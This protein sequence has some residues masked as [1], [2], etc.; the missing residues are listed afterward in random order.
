MILAENHHVNSPSNMVRETVQM[1]RL[2]N[3]EAENSLH[4][5]SDQNPRQG[6]NGRCRNLGSNGTSSQPCYDEND[7]E[8]NRSGISTRDASDNLNANMQPDVIHKKARQQKEMTFQDMYN[9]QDLFDD[10]DDDSDWEPAQE[11]V[12]IKKWFC[13][14]CTMV[15]L[16]DT[17]HCDIC[18]E[19]K[20]SGIL[21]HGFFASPFSQDVG[22]AEVESEIKERHRDLGCPISTLN[23]STAVGFDERM[24]LHS[25][26]E[27]KSHPHPERPDRLRAISAS[28]ATAGIFPG[29]CYPISAR[30]ITQEELKKV[31][32]LEHIEAVELTSHLL[33]SY[34]T[35]DT[36]A[37]E[38]SA[39]AA[40]LAA[41]LCA[42]LATAIF[43]GRAKNGFALVRPPGHHAGVRQAMGF[44]LH[45]NAAV[46]ALAAQVAGAKKVL[47]VD[48]DVHHG[49]GTQEIFDQNKSV[50]YISLHRHEGGKF[51]PGTGAAHEVGTMGAEGYCVNIPWSRGGVGDNDYVFAFQHVVL[52]IASEFAPDLTIISAGFDAARGDPLGCCDVTPAGYAQMTQM[53]TALSGGKLLVILEGGYNLR[54]ISSSATAVIKVLL[55]EI[56]E[57]GLDILPSK[58]GVQTVLEVLQI[59]MNFWPTLGPRFSDLQS[60][61]GTYC[62][63]NKKK[64]IKKRRL[65]VAP[66]WWKW[67]QKSLLYHLLNGHLHV[68]QRGGD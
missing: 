48:W 22:S 10:E 45:N 32:S 43:S 60:Q 47:I 1:S 31:H 66:L 56:P 11:R 29:R 37:N 63:K 16:D 21:R 24:L 65:A 5:Q 8:V 35:P 54:S 17:I 7:G 53:L 15:N 55:G 6:R 58:A 20:E 33:S 30:E 28:L 14:N 40:R 67:G 61:W 12:E 64:H 51:Y 59:Q 13:T 38:H 62:L 3:R 34:F 4:K 46:A 9:N 44:C 50:L 36:Y 41:G 42:D 27:M 23:S 26:V 25:E 52:P 49:N 18:G 57:C 68:N 2:T 19:H 39:C